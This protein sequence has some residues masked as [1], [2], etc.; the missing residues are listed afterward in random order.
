MNNDKLKVNISK[1]Q[2]MVFATSKTRL[3]NLPTLKFGNI[4]LEQVEHYT[5]GICFN[6]NG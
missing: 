4:N 3:N 5:L 6:W 2:I 1:T